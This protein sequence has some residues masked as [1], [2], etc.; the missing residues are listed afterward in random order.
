MSFKIF[1]VGKETIRS[2]WQACV[3]DSQ[4]QCLKF[5]SKAMPKIAKDY[6]FEKQLLACYWDSIA[7]DMGHQ[8][9]VLPNCLS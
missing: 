2:L 9:I 4:N 8:V 6:L 5:W 7:Y 1:V 3:E